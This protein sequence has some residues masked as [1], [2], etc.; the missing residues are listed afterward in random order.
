LEA[1]RL[2]DW[3][4]TLQAEPEVQD[5]LL[6]KFQVSF[7][8]KSELQN[9]PQSLGRQFVIRGTGGRVARAFIFAWRHHRKK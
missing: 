3:Q 6:R 7:R 9:R 8:W 5:A 4:P 1:P 2:P